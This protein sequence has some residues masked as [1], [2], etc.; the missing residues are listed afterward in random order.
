MCYEGICTKCG[1]LYLDCPHLQHLSEEWGNRHLSLSS[2]AWQ[3]TIVLEPFKM[4][5]VFWCLKNIFGPV[6]RLLTIDGLRYLYIMHCS[7][8]LSFCWSAPCCN[9]VY[10]IKIT[11]SVLSPLRQSVSKAVRG[12][13]NIFLVLYVGDS[14]GFAGVCS[15][16]APWDE[17]PP[18]MQLWFWRLHVFLFI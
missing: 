7:L 18:S 17:I 16:G 2:M 8:I 13:L 12:L 11:L 14:C 1:A 6:Y 4:F 3:C 9:H 15:M 5:L 10:D